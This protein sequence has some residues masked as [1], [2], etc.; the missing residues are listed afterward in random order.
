MKLAK[1]T[2]NFLRSP[3]VD[4]C[5]HCPNS[6]FTGSKYQKIPTPMTDYSFDDYYYLSASKT[7]SKMNEKE[8][9]IDDSQQL[10]QL[11]SIRMRLLGVHRVVGERAGGFAWLKL[12]RPL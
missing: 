9:A 1:I 6:T 10:V 5:E 11:N 3:Y 12:P 8:H 2:W 7:P 4:T